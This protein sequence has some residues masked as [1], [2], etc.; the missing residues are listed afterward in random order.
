VR[1][2]LTY[3][4]G[5]L[6]KLRQGYVLIIKSKKADSPGITPSVPGISWIFLRVSF[7]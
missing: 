6:N 2:I 5:K 1:G 4:K 3:A 7:Y